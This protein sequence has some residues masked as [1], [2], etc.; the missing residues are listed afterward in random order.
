LFGQFTAFDG[1]AALDCADGSRIRV[2]EDEADE[3]LAFGLT[4]TFS[5]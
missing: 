3:C 5:R 2:R 4:V 1:F